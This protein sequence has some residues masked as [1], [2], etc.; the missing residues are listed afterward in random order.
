MNNDKYST[1]ITLDGK[2]LKVESSRRSNTFTIQ[3]PEL[4]LEI[5]VPY[6]KTAN[7]IR[8]IKNGEKP[9]GTLKIEIYM[10]GIGGNLQVVVIGDDGLALSEMQRGNKTCSLVFGDLGEGSGI[11]AIDGIG[12]WSKQVLLNKRT[13]GDTLAI[14]STFG[15]FQRQR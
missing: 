6:C 2:T 13:P 5:L 14:G 12:D 15:K 7:G 10:P 1:S 4:D 3:S 9:E 11:Y 8:R